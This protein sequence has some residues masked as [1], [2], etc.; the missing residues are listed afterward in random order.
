MDKRERFQEVRPV[1][2]HEC[3]Q[4][5]YR[6]VSANVT[7]VTINTTLEYYKQIRSG[8]KSISDLT[9]PKRRD[10]ISLVLTCLFF[11]FVQKK[12]EQLEKQCFL[13]VH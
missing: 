13:F 1:D 12:Q 6:L 5:N 10:I 8:L 3:W 2:L 4:N 7:S 11:R 9:S